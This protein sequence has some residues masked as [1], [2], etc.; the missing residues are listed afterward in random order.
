MDRYYDVPTADAA[1]GLIPRQIAARERMKTGNFMTGSRAEAGQRPLNLELPFVTLGCGG[2]TA[3]LEF[4]WVDDLEPGLREALAADTAEGVRLRNPFFL[5]MQLEGLTLAGLAPLLKHGTFRQKFGLRH[6]GGECGH[7]GG[8][9]LGNDAR[10][11]LL[12]RGHQ[13]HAR[14]WT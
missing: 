8:A 1:A 4:N 12:G 9:R 7:C 13:R 11:H 2:M 3:H 10:G 5:A 6:A 14:R